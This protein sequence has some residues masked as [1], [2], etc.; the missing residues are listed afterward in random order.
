[1][2]PQGAPAPPS[3][4]PAAAAAPDASPKVDF[5]KYTLP[6]GLQVILH[7]DRK[8]PIVH[9]NQW[10]HVGS[11]NERLGRTGFA[12]LFEHMMFQGSQNVKGEYFTVVEKAGANLQE[13]GVNGTTN[14]DRTNYFATV[15]SGN[16]ETLLWLESDRLAT[17][18]DAT[19]QAK[20][21][22]QRD[23]VKNERRQG[24]ENQPYGRWYS[25]LFENLFPAGHP[26]SWP[27]IG[28]QEDLTAASLD[29]VKD[30]FRTYYSPN[31]LS[32]AIAGDFDPAQAKA[33]VAKYFGGIPAGPALD[34]PARFLPAVASEKVVEVADRVPQERVYLGWISPPYFA[35]GD[36]ELELASRILSDGLSSRLNKVL[37]YDKQLCTGVQSFQNS[38]EIASAF[39]V[40]ATARPG[41]K[42]SEI[43]AIITD[44]IARLAKAGPTAAELAR[45]QTKQEFDF[46]SNL[47]RIGG[48]GGKADILN[49]YNT[50][51]GDPGKMKED[52][53]RYRKATAADV[54]KTVDRWL[55][56]SSRVLLRF[57]PENSG[58]ADQAALDRSTEPP[59]GADRAFRA[60]EVGAAKLENGLQVFVVERSDLPKVAVAFTTRAGAIADPPGKEGLAQLTVANIDMGTPTRKALAIEEALGDLG[61]SLEGFAAR[62]SANLSFE[63]LKR[64][65]GATLAIVSDVV[66]N[67]AF[68][69][70]ELERERA[71]HL[72]NL[73]QQ[74]K[75]PNAI[76]N[77]VRSQLA[78][79][80]AH[81][82]GR[83]AAGLPSTVQGITRQDLQAFHAERWRPGSSAIV[84]VGAVSLNEAVALARTHF[85]GWKGA[86]AAA[87]DIP[88]PQPAAAG[89][90]YLIDR[91]DSAQSVITQFLPA[92]SR[93]TDDYYALQLADAV[94]GG[95]GFG[96]RLNLNLRED[97]GY[98]YGVFSSLALFQGSGLWFG[99]GGVQTNKTKESVVEFQ[100]ELQDLAGSRPISAAEFDVAKVRWVRGYAQKFESFSRVAE[101]VADLWAQELPM[102]ELQAE[103]DQIE[104]TKLEATL[105][106][107]KK[108][109]RPDAASLL[110]VGD[111]AKIEPG[112][113]ELPGVEVVV[114]D[115]EGKPAR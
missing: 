31:N 15:P 34:R 59:L 73:A 102:T 72:D 37:V 29:D 95:G 16:L 22:N 81:P 70:E 18:L 99:G 112:L 89:K 66:R 19:D 51:L 97:K 75:N 88:A 115:A 65:L 98:S 45:A 52:L 107:A 30:F 17:L 50:F 85:A 53:A 39:I 11:K 83:P 33:L 108:Y 84:F 61:A 76:A 58:R 36:A 35:A 82:Y 113:R 1:A 111:R 92:P 26:Y 94:W 100:K 80:P 49:Q 56:T 77:R 32:L 90:V 55:N 28:S 42:L 79:G 2:L 57:H 104:S 64:N 62:E 67:P 78:F 71:R 106:A 63:V 110:I 4:R 47:E 10:F 54:Q 114:L 44:E 101:Q 6:N 7:V 41:A 24:L 13:G 109:A 91:Q 46:V 86:A 103:S 14:N 38:Q 74:A 105:A 69:A 8:L 60:P 25:L 21:D 12:H 68:P 27:V 40:I 3:P 43:E 20:L 93:R 9:V 87:V 23:V 96:T 48:F 5:E